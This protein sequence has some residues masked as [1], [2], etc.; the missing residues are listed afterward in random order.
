ME[1]AAAAD[2]TVLLE[3]RDR[4]REEPGR[5]VH[6][7]PVEPPRSPLPGRGLRCDAAQPPRV[8]A[9]RPRE[10]RDSPARS[11][12]GWGCSRRPAAAPSSSTRSASCPSS[13]SPSSSGSSRRGRSAG[14]NQHLHP[15]GRPDH[16][17]HQPRPPRPR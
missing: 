17:R 12:A 7:P 1:R 3:G 14:W 8:G 10:G 15:G 9:L 13:S 6:P 16:H 2:V 5:G 4:H 11:P